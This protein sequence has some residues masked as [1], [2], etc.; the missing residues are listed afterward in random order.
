MA[1]EKY[2]SDGVSN[3]EKVRNFRRFY[4]NIVKIETTLLQTS[5]TLAPNWVE[6]YF[7]NGSFYRSQKETENIIQSSF[8]SYIKRTKYGLLFTFK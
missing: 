2:K 3:K 5:Y 7:Q 8:V 1:D 4:K 6:L